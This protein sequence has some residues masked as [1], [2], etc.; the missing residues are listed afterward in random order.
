MDRLR[1]TGTIFER[2]AHGM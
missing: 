2:V 1:V